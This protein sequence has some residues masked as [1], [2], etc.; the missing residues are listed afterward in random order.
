ML[1]TPSMAT[2]NNIQETNGQIE[3]G[4]RKMK[5]LTSLLVQSHATLVPV[6]SFFNKKK[7]FS[8]KSNTLSLVSKSVPV[9]LGY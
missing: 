7:V 3:R 9:T 8:S 2:S 1:G 4:E 6:C 5:N